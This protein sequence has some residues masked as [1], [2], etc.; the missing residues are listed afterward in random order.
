LA[1]A[2]KRLPQHLRFLQVVLEEV[3]AAVEAQLLREIKRVVEDV[4]VRNQRRSRR[5]S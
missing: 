4:V 3:A 5:F 2:S 1:L